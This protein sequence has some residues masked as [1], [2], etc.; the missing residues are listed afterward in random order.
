MRVPTVR[1]LAQN[2]ARSYES[3]DVPKLVRLRSKRLGARAPLLPARATQDAPRA[4]RLRAPL[5]PTRPA[6]RA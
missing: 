3:Y 1:A 5:S 4:R 2:L 6:P